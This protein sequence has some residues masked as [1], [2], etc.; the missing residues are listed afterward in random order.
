MIQ[1]INNQINGEIVNKN[2]RSVK[3]NEKWN[4][5]YFQ[6]KLSY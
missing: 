1:M 4:M 6:S 3:D 2:V 5:N